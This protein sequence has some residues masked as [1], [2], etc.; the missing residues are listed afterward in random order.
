MSSVFVASEARYRPKLE[1]FEIRENHSR[2]NGL[3]IRPIYG[4]VDGRES[5]L[6]RLLFPNRNKVFTLDRPREERLDYDSEN[7]SDD[8]EYG[9]KTKVILLDS[10]LGKKWNQTPKSADVFVDK[11]RSER[12]IDSD[13]KVLYEL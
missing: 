11:T 4:Q 1:L 12:L 5:D 9:D 7:Y 3:H 6:V 2:N 10:V 8:F 13:S